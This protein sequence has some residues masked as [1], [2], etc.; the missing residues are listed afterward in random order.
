MADENSDPN[1]AGGGFQTTR[2]SLVVAAGDSR[3]PDCQDALAELCQVYWYPIYA[4]VRHREKS[5]DAA[6]DLTQDFFAHLLEKRTL[7]LA[8]PGRGRFRSF[9]LTTLR[10]YLTKQHHRATAQKRGGGALPI[11]LDFET[12]EARYR[13]ERDN[14]ETPE[15]QFEKRWARTLLS[16][17]LHHLQ[18]EAE[19]ASSGDR[20]RTLEPFL[21]G[22]IPTARY[23]QIAERLNMTE[24]AVKTAVRGMRGR[25]GK[26][27]RK[28][29]AQT[30]KDP[31]EID[32]EI[33][34]LFSVLDS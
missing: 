1:R 34:Y 26:L 30:V 20:F 29:V 27:L 5:P 17:V 21:T 8:D 15:R 24:D 13:R 32:D 33:R 14:L 22:R 7:R 19:A 10:N 23:S 16:R 6:Q 25:F 4:Q 9:L 28:E 11:T 18:E 2:W 31:G 3:N 12:G